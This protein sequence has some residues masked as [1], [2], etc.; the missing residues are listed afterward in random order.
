M[1]YN[2][3]TLNQI[4]IL[5]ENSD[6]FYCN[7]KH[8]KGCIKLELENYNL[9]KEVKLE[10]IVY[11][12]MCAGCEYERKCHVQCEVCED[13]TNTLQE[14]EEMINGDEKTKKYLDRLEKDL[15]FISTQGFQIYEFSNERT[16]F[17]VDITNCPSKQEELKI[18]LENILKNIL[19]RIN[20]NDQ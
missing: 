1:K 7:L 14:L 19:K 16:I 5:C 8:S 11:Q 12:K 10:E 13:Y 20:N 6:C 3:L 4:K 2:E 15:K 17:G 18:M 9:D